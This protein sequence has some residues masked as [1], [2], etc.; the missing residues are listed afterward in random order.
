MPVFA[1]ERNTEGAIHKFPLTAEEL[2]TAAKAWQAVENDVFDIKYDVEHT[3]QAFLWSHPD[4]KD[5]GVGY[6]AKTVR[7][8]ALDAAMAGFDTKAPE[9]VLKALRIARID[10]AVEA[11]LRADI[12]HRLRICLSAP[13]DERTVEAIFSARP[14]RAEEMAGSVIEL[15]ENLPGE[16]TGAPF[17]LKDP[18]D[19]IGEYLSGGATAHALAAILIRCHKNGGKAEYQVQA[20]GKSA[21]RYGSLWQAVERAKTYAGADA[22]SEIRNDKENAVETE[23]WCRLRGTPENGAD[24][25]DEKESPIPPPSGAPHE[26]AVALLKEKKSKLY[27]PQ[28]N[29]LARRIEADGGLSSE[30]FHR[31]EDA[32]DFAKHGKD[33]VIED[34]VKNAVIWTTSDGWTDAAAL[35]G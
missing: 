14:D 6:D 12:L 20:D 22:I 15:A 27:T 1:I 19:F 3:F 10:D 32:L 18:A 31:L 2:E 11:A 4:L 21:W 23:L 30:K 7:Q 26:K 9:P 28:D 13:V 8:I 33:G 29:Y 34:L 25:V 17:C 24:E 35:N 16:W 5:I